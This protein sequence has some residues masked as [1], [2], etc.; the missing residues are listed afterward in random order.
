MPPAI[1]EFETLWHI[2]WVR[3]VETAKSGLQSTL[4]VRHPQSN[5]LHVNVDHQILELLRESKCL[6]RIGYEIP[7]SA[8]MVL[9]QE[10]KFKN[11]L[12]AALKAKKNPRTHMRVTQI[13]TPPALTWCS[14]LVLPPSAPT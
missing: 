7:D 5:K 1:V 12:C 13:L 8:K 9:M 4:I 6:M 11:Y 2:A 10:S 14:P 3:G